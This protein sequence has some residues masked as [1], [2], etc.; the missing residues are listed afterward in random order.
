MSGKLLEKILVGQDEDEMKKFM[1][2]SDAEE[3]RG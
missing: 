3:M 1:D 2:I